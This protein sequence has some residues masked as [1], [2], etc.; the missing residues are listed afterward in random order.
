KIGWTQLIT[1]SNNFKF[2]GHKFRNNKEAASSKENENYFHPKSK[3]AEKKVQAYKDS[4]GNRLPGREEL[5]YPKGGYWKEGSMLNPIGSSSQDKRVQQFKDDSDSHDR[6]GN[7]VRKNLN[8]PFAVNHGGLPDLDNPQRKVQK[9]EAPR[10]LGTSITHITI[11]FNLQE[12]QSS[13][14]LRWLSNNAQYHGFNNITTE[15]EIEEEDL[16]DV[17]LDF[18]CFRHNKPVF[19]QTRPALRTIDEVMQKRLQICTELEPKCDSPAMF[20]N[21][22]IGWT[23]LITRSNNFKFLG[24]KFCNNKEAS[25]S[26]E[27]ENYL[28]PKSKLAEKRFKPISKY[29]EIGLS[30][31]SHG[32]R[33][34]GREEL[35]SPKG[36]Y[37]K[38]GSMLKPIGSSSQDKRVQ[39]FKNGV[40]SHD[41]RGNVVSVR[42]N[43]DAATAMK[44]PNHAGFLSKNNLNES[45]AVNHGGLPDLD[46]PQR[47]VQKDEAPTLK[48]Y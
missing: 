32:N 38:E 34:P 43:Q 1:R 30:R 42:K 31:D 4:H 37:W 24:H 44:S 48:P 46:N 36:G 2:L 17:Y 6:R 39:Q 19:N 7:V 5:T 29:N 45:F 3:L 18:P 35:T 23:Q 27:D 22:K 13:L 20:A 26:K 41:K 11:F 9:D 33:L 10:I 28:H 16:R 8:E 25:S 15:R 14:R 12:P 21:M 40:D 47:K